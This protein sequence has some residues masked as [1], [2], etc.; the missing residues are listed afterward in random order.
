[1]LCERGVAEHRFVAGAADEVDAAIVS[2][3]TISPADGKPRP[4]SEAA[5]PW[6]GQIEHFLACIE[7]GAEPRDG[8]FAQA[9]AALAVA[10]AA[11]RSLE[12][13]LPEPV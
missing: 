3:L 8:S 5:D 1:V 13:G 9:R 11:R 7:A 10:L 12:T 2:A 6:R 4:F